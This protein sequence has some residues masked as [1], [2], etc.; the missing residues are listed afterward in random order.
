METTNTVLDVLISLIKGA[1]SQWSGLQCDYEGQHYTLWG[2]SYLLDQALRLYQIPDDHYLIS[3]KAKDLWTEITTKPIKDFNYQRPVTYEFKEPL[4]AKCFTGNGN[5]FSTRTLKQNDSF[6]YRDVFHDD[7]VV[8]LK[9]I[10]QELVNLDEISYETV[11]PI[12]N[13][14]YICRM[15]KEE[16]RM[17]KNKTARANNYLD[18]IHHLYQEKGMV[19]YDLV[20]GEKII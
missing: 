9:I 19:I 20:S 5:G 15:L 17:L 3:E 6:P 1:K 10:I 11:L 8:P 14:I 18:V 4:E 16:D 2:C 12:L 7:H 13:K